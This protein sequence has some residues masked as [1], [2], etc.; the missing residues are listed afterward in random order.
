MKAMV[1][2]KCVPFLGVRYR[3]MGVGAE[4]ARKCCRWRRF[5]ALVEIQ[6]SI[7]KY[8]S[9]HPANGGNC[10]MMLWLT[11]AQDAAVERS[12]FSDGKLPCNMS[13]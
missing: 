2:A 6:C 4:D 11:G 5:S 7:E 8:N 1:G 10:S 9:S 13:E 12:S 3:A